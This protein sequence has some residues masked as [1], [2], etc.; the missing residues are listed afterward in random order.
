MKI[1]SKKVCLK[2]TYNL[3]CNGVVAGESRISILRCITCGG[4]FMYDPAAQIDHLALVDV[5]SRVAVL[6]DCPL[7][8]RRLEEIDAVYKRDLEQYVA[9]RRN[10]LLQRNGDVSRDY[11]LH[12]M[13]KYMCDACGGEEADE[14]YKEIRRSVRLSNA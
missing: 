12:D 11:L 5:M 2:C 6:V 10:A 8:M 14:L 7:L 13:R 1:E 3:M 9:L 4:Y